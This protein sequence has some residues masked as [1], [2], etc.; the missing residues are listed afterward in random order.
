[1]PT[2]SPRHQQ[3][4]K[5]RQYLMNVSPATVSWY[6]HA[7]KWLSLCANPEEPTADELQSMVMRMRE[8][9]LKETGANAVIRA[10][11][12]YLHW[13]S[14]SSR[15]CGAGCTHPRVL[16][17]KEPE[18]I[19]ATFTAPQIKL[20]V[21]FKPKTFIDRRTHL[22][23]LILFDTGC[24]IS[25]ALGLRIEDCEMEDLLIKF[26]AKGRKQY[27]VPISLELRRHLYRYV[28]E[29]DKK[30]H[31]LLLSAQDGAKLGRCVCL[32]QVKRLCL[33][34]DFTP[35]PRTLHSF[36]TTFSVM[37][38]R[39]GGSVFHLQKYLNH[40]TLEMSR[41]YANLTTDDLSATHQRHSLLAA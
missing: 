26:T 32:R 4:V 7:F 15:K 5:E 38:I 18:F 27:R 21:N 13:A 35:P 10:T 25:S 11:N 16:N 14:K 37:Y 8:S 40:S 12:A 6:T 22:L 9:G 3:F 19:P 41:K 30:P 33:R 23:C 17:L 36:R 1:M 24:R 34:L 28:R 39:R 31:D 20:L 29:C 2:L